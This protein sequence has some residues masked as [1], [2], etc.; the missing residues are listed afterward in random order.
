MWLQ[1]EACIEEDLVNLRDELE[2]KRRQQEAS[3]DEQLAHLREELEAERRMRR[4]L[5][6]SKGE[7]LRFLRA[8]LKKM[9]E[10]LQ[11]ERQ[12]TANE[13]VKQLTLEHEEEKK[14]WLKEEAFIEKKDEKSRNGSDRVRVPA[15]MQN[16]YRG[17]S[18]KLREELEEKRRE[19]GAISDKL[20]PCLQIREGYC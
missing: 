9:A 1:E 4:Q 14:L 7:E 12:T 11:A 13:K 6:E 19:E 15:T 10:D 16:M 18:G 3:Y 17:R 20:L 2:E 5:E 8:E